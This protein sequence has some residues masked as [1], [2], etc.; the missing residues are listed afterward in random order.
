MWTSSYAALGTNLAG[1]KLT[2]NTFSFNCSPPMPIVVTIGY[3]KPKNEC[4]L[5]MEAP[6]EE[7]DIDTD[8]DGCFYNHLSDKNYPHY[9]P[10]EFNEFWRTLQ[11]EKSGTGIMPKFTL[12]SS[13]DN[14]D[15]LRFLEVFN[16][17]KIFVPI[18]IY[19]ILL[20]PKI[21]NVFLGGYTGEVQDISSLGCKL[22]GVNTIDYYK[23]FIHLIK[24]L[25]YCD[26]LDGQPITTEQAKE[27]LYQKKK[28]ELYLTAAKYNANIYQKDL[29]FSPSKYAIKQQPFGPYADRFCTPTDP[30]VIK[31]QACTDLLTN[32]AIASAV[33][34]ESQLTLSFNKG[35]SQLKDI[36]TVSTK[37]EQQQ[38]CANLDKFLKYIGFGEQD[39]AEKMLMVNPEL[40]LM[41]GKLRDCANRTFEQVTGFQY[42]VWALDWHM[43]TMI[44]KYL[45]KE[46]AAE[47]AKS[48]RTVSWVQEH[49]A[50]ASWQ[51]LID[52]LQAYVKHYGTWTID[53]CQ[54]HWNKQVGG[55]QRLLPAHVIN[56]YCRSDRSFEPCPDFNSPISLPRTRNTD[57]G[58]WHTATYNNGNLGDTFAYVRYSFN[59]SGIHCCT[60]YPSPVCCGRYSP[61]V[62]LKACHTL[63]NIRMQQRDELFAE[64]NREYQPQARA[65]VR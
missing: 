20:E 55:A 61:G 36:K 40:A 22:Y 52:A 17:Y 45:S 4:F 37:K 31:A 24:G 43:W 44:L 33:S 21:R 63:L 41:S 58:E 32:H 65:S 47:Q 16:E 49:G 62:D 11:S 57:E 34:E 56:E 64:L 8:G 50:S 54:E 9:I 59:T 39:E 42:A 46:K 27:P 53:Q 13:Q 23:N 26:P 38:S 60:S 3:D 1:V 30:V 51:N 28:E 18:D 15:L 48:M 14:K 6:K 29:F 10:P 25:D 12:N 7:G 35:L 19:Q 2:L 5:Y